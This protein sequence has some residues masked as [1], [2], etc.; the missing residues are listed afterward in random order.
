MH[1]VAINKVNPMIQ[2]YARI[3]R[4]IIE[5]LEKIPLKIKFN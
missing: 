4:L 3:Y 5:S 1:S 2:L